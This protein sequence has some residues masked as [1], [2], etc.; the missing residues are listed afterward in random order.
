MPEDIKLRVTGMSCEHC[1]MHVTKAAEGV[2][3][4]TD[5]KVDLASGS[6][7][8]KVD[9]PEKVEEIRQAVADAGYQAG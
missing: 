2:E 3:G 7:E 9:S 8:A 4:V 5:V 1:V 6:L